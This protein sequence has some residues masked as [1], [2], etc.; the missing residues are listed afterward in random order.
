ML[1]RDFMD[2]GLDRERIDGCAFLAMT[3]H[4][5]SACLPTRRDAA[6]TA[7]CSCRP[8]FLVM[9]LAGTPSRAGWR[10]SSPLHRARLLAVDEWGYLPSNVMRRFLGKHLKAG[11]RTPPIKGVREQA[12]LNSAP[13]LSKELRDVRNHGRAVAGQTRS[14]GPRP[15]RS[16]RRAS[17]GPSRR[18]ASSP[19]CCR[20]SGRRGSLRANEACA[21]PRP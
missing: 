20:R 17:R 7:R 10:R 13:Q 15:R 1:G 3:E 8:G 14:S 4:G 9:R 11:N 5:R 2:A 19:L 16:S 6:P 18:S 21:A 12:G